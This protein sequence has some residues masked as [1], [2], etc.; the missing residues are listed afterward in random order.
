ML[1]VEQ[2]DMLVVCCLYFDLTPG[3]GWADGP[4]S[5]LPGIFYIGVS[6][7]TLKPA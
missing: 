6:A 2:F 1:I 4:Q 3:F 5:H 7:V